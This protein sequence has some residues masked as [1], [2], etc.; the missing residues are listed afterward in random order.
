MS[1]PGDVAGD[2]I[3]QNSSS[4]EIAPK[5]VGSQLL[6]MTAVSLITLLAFNILRPKNKVIY[7]P[8]VKYHIGN[9]RPPPISPGLFSWISPLIHVKEPELMDK[10]GLDAVTF[11]RFLR[12]MRWLFAVISLL[13]CGV[14][15]PVNV[16]YN[17]KNVNQKDRD[18]LSQMTIAKVGGKILFVHVGI[19]YLICFAVMGFTYFHWKRMVELRYQ[20]FRSDEYVQSFYARTLMVSKVPKQLQSDEGLRSLFAS[21]QV[22]YPTTSVHIGRRVGRLPE[23]IK[24]HNDAVCELEQVLVTY[25]RG[26]KIGKKRPTITQG[27]FLGIGGKKVDAIDFYTNKLRNTERAI[28]DWRMKIDTRKAEPYGFASMAAVPYAHIVA[29]LLRGKRK[30]GTIIQLAPNPKDIIWEN[31]NQSDAAVARKKTLGWFWM[32][33]VCFFNTVPLL[34][35]SILAN[36]QSLTA[37][38]GFL[39]DWQQKSGTTFAIVSGVLPP[40]VS[41]IFGYFFPIIMRWL[42]Q[43]QG[44]T[45]N[46]RLDRAVVARYF[47]FLIISQL[48]IFT[49]IGVIFNSVKQIISQIGKHKSFQEILDNLHTL[50]ATINSTYIEQSSYWLTF[51]PL[52]GFLVL[53]DLAQLLNLIWTTIRTHLFGRTVRDIREWTKPPEFE[54]AT[55]YSNMLFMAAVGLVFAPLAPLVSLGA[56]VVFWIS[57]MVHKYQMMFVYVTKVESGGR[58]W[59]VVVNRLLASV[60]FMQLLMVLTIG[61]QLGFRTF[62]WVSTIPPIL[63]IFIFKIYLSRTFVK[64]FRYYIPTDAEIQ[65]AKIHSE[66]ADNKS[67]RLEKRF[68]HPALHTELFTPMLH[69]SMMPLL[70]QVYSGRLGTSESA[71][72]EFGGQKMETSVAPGGI[73][74]A[75]VEQRDLEYDPK[76]YQRDRG[77]LDWDAKSVASQAYLSNPNDPRA[78]MMSPPPPVPK[79]G[80]AGYE[81][82]MA[83]G[84]G[85]GFG[86]GTP[87]AIELSRLDTDSAP[88]LSAPLYYHEETGESMTNL[89]EYRDHPPAPPPGPPPGAGYGQSGLGYGRPAP[90]RSSTG[91]STTD[92]GYAY[93]PRPPSMTPQQSYSTSPQQQQPQQ[94]QQRGYTRSPPVPRHRD[95]DGIREAPLQRYGGSNAPPGPGEIVNVQA[96]TGGASR[97]PAQR[98]GSN[99]SDL[100]G[101]GTGGYRRQ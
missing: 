95:S 36:I 8:K 80:G 63:F 84:P 33:V 93:P 9:K 46:S 76:L 20:F 62:L 67:H 87:D 72:D 83:G 99:M 78:G 5:A 88:L 91:Y 1:N 30:Q 71:L 70:P 22:P 6:L 31:L 97:P 45:T 41:A 64:Q 38:V 17:L 47:A 56:C 89:Q 13:A 24:Y 74:I 101:R 65:S 53:F 14:L 54:Y 50:P 82:Y 28:E 12:M 35:I 16:V 26:G 48:V 55:Y 29:K 69:S 40:A 18:P 100:A 77:E 86:G 4:R 39:D 10:V 79:F 25:L 81:E 32:A 75:S 85:P 52:R 90:T 15:I 43:Y 3:D 96:L 58:L 68:G 92:G 44:A 37:W 94:Q 49:L 23:L 27:G 2:I 51:F 34:A 21:L 98:Q 11:L 66:R 42:S 60:I 61:L 59:N 73:K 57:S 7:E 19:S